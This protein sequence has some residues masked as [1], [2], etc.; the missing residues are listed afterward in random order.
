M[1]LESLIGTRVDVALERM[2][3]SDFRMQVLQ[4]AIPL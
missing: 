2:L 3:R 1:E 4:E